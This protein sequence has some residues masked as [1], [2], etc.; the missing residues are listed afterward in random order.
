MA[1]F[2]VGQQLGGVRLADAR[3][4]P[5]FVS[6][7]TGITHWLGTDG[8]GR[9]VLS[10]ILYGL[11][12]SLGVGAGSTLKKIYGFRVDGPWDPQQGAR[13]NHAKLLM[14]PYARALDG[15]FRL[16]PAVFAHEGDDDLVR[17]DADSAPFVPRS[18]A[19]TTSFDWY[20]DRPPQT[21]WT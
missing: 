21:P 10:A 16:D 11:R 17:N 13:W 9:D 5:G 14:D 3:R 20:D 7:G 2:R 1:L 6:P 12:I 19:V 15:E 18:I 8:Q 4:P